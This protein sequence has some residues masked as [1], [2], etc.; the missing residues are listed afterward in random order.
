MTSGGIQLPVERHG[1]GSPGFQGIPRISNDGSRGAGYFEKMTSGDVVSPVSGWM[2][3]NAALDGAPALG[4]VAKKGP[5]HFG[6][7][8]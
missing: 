2:L 4:K 3:R 1:G 6:A 8:S 7:R 5:T